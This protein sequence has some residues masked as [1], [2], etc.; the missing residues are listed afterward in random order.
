[1]Q[2][3][4][5]QQLLKRIEKCASQAEDA[6]WNPEPGEVE[7]GVRGVIELADEL[8][9]VA[10]LTDPSV[11]RSDRSAR[12]AIAVQPD[13]DDRTGIALAAFDCTVELTLTSDAVRSLVEFS[14]RGPMHTEQLEVLKA[15]AT[16][17]LALRRRLVELDA[18]AR[19]ALQAQLD[20]DPDMAGS[21]VLED[22][23]IRFTPEGGAKFLGQGQ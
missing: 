23:T 8:R 7:A 16:R 5:V 18:M 13:P 12:A 9:N 4:P 22:G 20:A 2:A 15:A 19:A 14:G 10:E 17:G 1:V 21:E 6:T 3:D 11:A